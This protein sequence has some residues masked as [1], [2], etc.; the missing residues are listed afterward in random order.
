MMGQASVWIIGNGKMPRK[1]REHRG[2][3]RTSIGYDTVFEPKIQSIELSTITKVEVLAPYSMPSRHFSVLMA[4]MAMGIFLQMFAVTYPDLW[5]FSVLPATCAMVGLLLRSPA[6]SRYKIARASGK[7]KI[8][9]AYKREDEADVQRMFSSATWNDADADITAELLPEE[10]RQVAMMRIGL[11]AMAMGFSLLVLL[12]VQH[13]ASPDAG[14]IE[15][16]GTE[17]SKYIVI[18]MLLASWVR[19]GMVMRES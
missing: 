11:V 10:K 13:N 5:V 19:M 8:T 14:E 4:G 2:H 15:T 18:A 3:M 1:M 7:D 12:G 6:M 9:F 16:W 17:I